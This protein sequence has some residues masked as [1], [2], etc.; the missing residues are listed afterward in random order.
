M[1][2]KLLARP[3]LIDHSESEFVVCEQARLLTTPLK[4]DDSI[5]V[6]FCHSWGVGEGKFIITFENFPSRLL[7]TTVQWIK[8]RDLIIDARC[9]GWIS[10]AIDENFVLRHS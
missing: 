1:E 10:E 8:N 4:L 5:V 7:S 9:L 6:V 2:Q 3:H